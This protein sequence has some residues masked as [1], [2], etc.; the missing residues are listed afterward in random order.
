MYKQIGNYN[1]SDSLISVKL[2]R[3]IGIIDWEYYIF[4]FDPK[5]L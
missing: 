2:S 1:S 5:D 4:L 3:A